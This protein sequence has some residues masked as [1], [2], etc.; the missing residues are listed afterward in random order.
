[1]DDLW[2][3]RVSY[4]GW[5]ASHSQKHQEIMDR[6]KHL[7]DDEMIRY[8]RYE[9]MV[10][11]EPN[12]CPLYAEGKQCHEMEDLNCYLCACPNFRF[13]D[14]G[15]EREGKR[16]LYSYCSIDSKSGGQFVSKDAIHQDCSKCLVPHKEA[17][18]REH[19][20]RD[21]AEIMKHTDQSST[22]SA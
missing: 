5:I 10:E 4:S 14:D 20:S 7:D 16:R 6:L 12:F 21:W 19:F 15:I 3:Q 8:F 22:P 9:N 2:S 18:I 11:K 13:D 17:Y 1:M